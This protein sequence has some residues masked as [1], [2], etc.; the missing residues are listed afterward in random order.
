MHRCPISRDP[1]RPASW[2]WGR[3]RWPRSDM[4]SITTSTIC[5]T[6]TPISAIRRGS[7]PTCLKG[8]ADHDVM[9][10]SRYV[11]G[12]GVEGGFKLKRRLMSGGNQRL[13]PSVAR[14]DQQGQQR[15]VSVLPGQQA[16]RD[17]PEPGSVARLLVP[18]RDSLLVPDRRLPDRRNADPVREPPRRQLEDQHAR[19]GLGALDPVAAGRV[20]TD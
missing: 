11:P 15:R 2:A 9:I 3:R 4:R 16:G 12:G 5:S 14:P 7:F 20:A 19:G 10:G 13:R 18:G 17:R 6:S 8:M 1:S